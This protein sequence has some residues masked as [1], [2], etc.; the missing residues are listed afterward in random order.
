M[1]E[2]KHG[3]TKVNPQLQQI[4]LSTLNKYRFADSLLQTYL[5]YLYSDSS[6]LELHTSQFFF[7]VE[8]L[9]FYSSY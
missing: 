1:F 5:S 3:E 9:Q 4:T 2:S 7:Q 6:F 8:Y